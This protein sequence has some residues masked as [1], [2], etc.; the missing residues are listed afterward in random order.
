[1][2]VN[3]RSIGAGLM[4]VKIMIKICETCGMELGD[5]RVKMGNC[6]KIVTMK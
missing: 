4:D 6:C 2:I 3:P 1:M 5:F